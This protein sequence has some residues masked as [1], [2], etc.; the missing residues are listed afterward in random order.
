MILILECVYDIIDN[1]TKYRLIFILNLSKYEWFQMNTAKYQVTGIPA[2]NDNYIWAITSENNNYVALVDP[3]CAQ[4]CIAFIESQQLVLT[5]IL[6]THHHKDHTGG[7]DALRDYNKAKQRALTVYGPAND[8]IK[9]LDVKLSE[10][11][12]VDLVQLSL[13]FNVIDLPGHT[14]GH[15]AYTNDALVFCGDTLFS[16]GCGRLFEGSASQMFQSL[17]KL[18]NLAE[19]T[20]VFCTHE[21]TLAN[22]DF[23]LAVEPN[24]QDTLAYQAQVN[25]LRKQNKPS[26]PTSIGL[27]KKINP[28]LRC[29]NNTVKQAVNGNSSQFPSD[30][31][32]TF[33]ALRQW[34]DKF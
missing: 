5:D 24:N 32:A 28:F 15:I 22:I 27:E 10:D 33:A 11:D 16:A 9:G 4:S 13:N 31:I 34:K 14:K 30:D 7:I 19:D 17:A 23:A 1:D 6:I 26:L 21:Y 12:A 8:N 20:Q 18:A 2:F 3:G 25:L 29:Q